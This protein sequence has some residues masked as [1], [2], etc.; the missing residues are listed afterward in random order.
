MSR[1]TLSDLVRPLFVYECEGLCEGRAVKVGA[2][3]RGTTGSDFHIQGTLS[4]NPLYCSC[5][6]QLSGPRFT[7]S[8]V[9]RYD[10]FTVERFLWM[11]ERNNC[12]VTCTCMPDE[13]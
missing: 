8:K 3:R 2:V 1:I 5:N 9:I 4:I 13:A 7:N 6:S 11:T 12:I 10:E